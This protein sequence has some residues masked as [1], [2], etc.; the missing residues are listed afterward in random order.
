MDTIIKGLIFIARNFCLGRIY[1]WFTYYFIAI[2][3]LYFR[4]RD[5][6]FTKNVEKY[7]KFDVEEVKT[8][9]ANIYAVEHSMRWGLIMK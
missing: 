4:Y 5:V 3:F 6:H 2:I 8:L 1:S 9:I 7:V